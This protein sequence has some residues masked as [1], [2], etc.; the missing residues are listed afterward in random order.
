MVVMLIHAVASYECGG[1][2]QGIWRFPVLLGVHILEL[3][4]HKIILLLTVSQSEGYRSFT[5]NLVLHRLLLLL[6]GSRFFYFALKLA[7]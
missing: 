7:P 1:E 3:N 4:G 6:L 2:F 5:N